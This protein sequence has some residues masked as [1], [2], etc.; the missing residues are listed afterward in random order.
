MKIFKIATKF[1]ATLRKA[2]DEENVLEN[3]RPNDVLTVY[4]GTGMSQLYYLING[5]DA[6]EIKPR[7]YGGP[8]HAGIFVSPT[9]DLAERFAHYGEIIMELEVRA[10]NLHGTDYSGNIGR[11]SDPHGRESS[12]SLIDYS[13]ERY[14]NSFRPYLTYTMSQSNEPQ[15][16]LRGLVGPHQIRRIRYKKY[17][18]EPIWYSRSEFLELGFET[19]PAK[20]APGGRSR[21]LEDLGYDQSYP[22]YSNEDF[23]SMVSKKFDVE[24][25]KVRDLL[26]RYKHRGREFL[27]DLLRRGDI[28]ET[29]AKN[30]SERFSALKDLY[31]KLG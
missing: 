30:Y 8:R 6:N 5:F 13:K 22:N 4:H 7:Y 15:A 24:E 2:D 1:A 25:E 31:L 3:L 23:I 21:E 9:V 10:K 19:V 18:E 17:K 27:E 26:L 14:P 11:D 16:L 20:D 12:Q 28:G 29:A